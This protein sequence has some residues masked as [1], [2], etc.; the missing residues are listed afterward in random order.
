[1]EAAGAV[2]AA[3]AEFN[4]LTREQRVLEN[5]YITLSTRH[6][7]IVLRE[8]MAGFFPASVHVIEAALPP[9]RP[10]PSS[11]PRTAAAALASGL[12]V[13]I[14]ATFVLETVDDRIR[15]AQ[16]A[17]HVLGVPVLAQIPTHGLQPRAVPATA[18]IVVTVLLVLT[19]AI[20]AVARGYVTLS[21]SDATGRVRSVA[22]T[23]TLWAGDL[24]A[25][26]T[27]AR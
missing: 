21:T 22:G 8:N 9:V 18:I 23:I 27:Q 14:V 7:E 2:P 4:R 6:Q 13:G 20:A 24:G 3:E 10:V 26:V 12:L 16:E 25:R 1:M 5:N 11:F 17:E 19:L 15:G